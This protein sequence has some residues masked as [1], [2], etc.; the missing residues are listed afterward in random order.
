MG[1]ESDWVAWGEGGCLSLF[2]EGLGDGMWGSLSCVTWCFYVFRFVFFWQE[3]WVTK[4]I[5]DGFTTRMAWSCQSFIWRSF[6]E[7]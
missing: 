6:E 1:F 5:D 4:Q 2:E 3:I 7:G